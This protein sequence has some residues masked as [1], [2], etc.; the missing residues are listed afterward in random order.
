ML[1][2]AKLLSAGFCLHPEFMAI[3]GGGW[4]PCRFPAG[5]AY[6]H[7]R[8]YGAILF[9][10]GY[11]DHFRAET[12]RFPGTLYAKLMPPRFDGADRAC[13]QLCRLGIEPSDVRT[14]IVSHFHADHI[15]GLRDF[16]R[17][18]IVCARAGYRAIRAARGLSGLMHGL[19]PGLMPG[20]SEER[21]DYVDDLPLMNLPPALAAFGQGRDLF[22]DGSVVAVD[23]PGHSVGQ[24][25]LYVPDSPAGGLFMVSDAAW[26]LDA[27]TQLRPPPRLVTALLGHSESYLATLSKL[28]HLHCTHPDLLIRPAHCR[29]QAA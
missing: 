2:D 13:A 25:G 5:F 29:L 12:K 15:A 4:R 18:R 28:H 8:R 14:I 24:I 6:F 21:T 11:S 16:P 7:H 27:I 19:L 9:D 1:D 3:R 10:T 23:L 20:D 17:A 26:S 22:G